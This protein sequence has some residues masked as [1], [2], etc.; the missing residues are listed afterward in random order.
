MK[1]L[2]LHILDIAE[3]S[4]AAEAKN[5]HIH[6]S[7]SGKDNLLT[8]EIT[9]DGKGISKDMLKIVA[10]PFVT[11]KKSKKVGLGISLLKSACELAEGKLVIESNEGVGSTLKATFKLNHIDRKPLGDIKQTLEILTLGYQDVNF[12][13]THEKGKNIFK[14]DTNDL[15]KNIEYQSDT[16]ISLLNTVRKYLK[17]HHFKEFIHEIKV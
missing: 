7:E 6:I 5:I 16:S 2:S 9:D 14:F 8:L 12:I 17:D 11:T 13:F 1:D 3:N 4:I 10:D 15:K